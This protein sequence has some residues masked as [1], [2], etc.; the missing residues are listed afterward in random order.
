MLHKLYE[1]IMAM[2]YEQW[3]QFNVL[4]IFYIIYIPCLIIFFKMFIPG[5]WD[6]MK[7]RFKKNA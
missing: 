5:I 4:L 6:I 7:R 3:I 2:S 1:Y